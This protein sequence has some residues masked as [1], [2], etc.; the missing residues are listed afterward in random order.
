MDVELASSIS[1][2]QTGQHADQSYPSRPWAPSTM[3]MQSLLG[4][5]LLGLANLAVADRK[6]C[7]GAQFDAAEYVC[8]DDEFLCPVIAGEGLPHCLGTCYNKYMVGVAVIAREV[9]V[10]RASVTY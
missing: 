10:P 2:K 6:P 9:V 7:G 8:W 1:D 4:L 5:V 3:N